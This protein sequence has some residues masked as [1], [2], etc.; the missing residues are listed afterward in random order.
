MLFFCGCP[1]PKW[2]D[3]QQVSLYLKSG[4]V[5]MSL[6]YRSVVS[7]TLELHS[8]CHVYDDELLAGWEVQSEDLPRPF[9]CPWLIFFHAGRSD[10]LVSLDDFCCL[11]KG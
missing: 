7:H 9:L 5:L 1:T 6:C 10:R 11:S 4:T 8:N 3:L 2:H